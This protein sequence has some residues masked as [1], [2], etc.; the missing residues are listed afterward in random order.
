MKCAL[1]RFFGL[2]WLVS[3]TAAYAEALSSADLNEL[4]S[5]RSMTIRGDWDGA[6]G[7]FYFKPSGSVVLYWEGR[8]EEGKWEIKGSSVCISDEWWGDNWCIKFNS[9][10]AKGRYRLTFPD[11]ARATY[12]EKDFIEGNNLSVLKQ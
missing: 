6:S 8:S 1:I 7:G 12:E 11:G 4:I 10:R 9:L 5:G 3:G 2:L